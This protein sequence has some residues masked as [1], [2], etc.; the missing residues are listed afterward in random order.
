MSGSAAEKFKYTTFALYLF[1]CAARRK[2]AAGTLVKNFLLAVF[3]TS[4]SICS[5]HVMLS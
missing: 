5:H 1:E 4:P 3:C 2:S